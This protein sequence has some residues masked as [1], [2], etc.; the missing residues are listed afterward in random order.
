MEYGPVGG[1]ADDISLSTGEIVQSRRSTIMHVI[2]N[3]NTKK[4]DQRDLVLC[5]CGFLC[6]REM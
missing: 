6:L 1:D 2:R 3:D 4:R 5:R